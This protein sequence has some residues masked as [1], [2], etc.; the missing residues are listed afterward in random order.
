MPDPIHLDGLDGANPLGFLAALGTLVLADHIWPGAAMAWRPRVNSYR[1]T[2]RCGAG[3]GREL[4]ERLAKFVKDDLAAAPAWAAPDAIGEWSMAGFRGLLVDA[5]ADEADAR[6]ARLLTGL[7]SDLIAKSDK[8][9]DGA[10][11]E[12]SLSHA[13]GQGGQKLLKFYRDMAEIV[14]ADLLAGSLLGRWEYAHA[15]PRFRWDPVDGRNFSV[16]T[17]S[18]NTEP[19]GVEVAANLLAFNAVEL[20]PTYPTA[21]GLTTT[22][23]ARIKSPGETRSGEYL[24]WPIWREAVSL[25]VVR[26][27]IASG[28]LTEPRPDPRRLAAMGVLSAMRTRRTV[29]AQKNLFFGEAVAV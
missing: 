6:P 26:G 1:P 15:K 4:A 8:E 28:E 5:L 11:K 16:G 18:A 25:D 10:V 29:D 12:T 7:A 14:D 19:A 22:G 23:Y 17:G 13:N 9:P 27:L 20:L 2:L 3:D 24:T 21:A